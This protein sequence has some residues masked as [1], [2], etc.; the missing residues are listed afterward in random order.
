MRYALVTLLFAVVFIAG[1]ITPPSTN[2][3]TPPILPGQK[4]C[5]IVID[6]EPYTELE[7]GDVSY[8]DEVCVIRKLDYTATESP[9]VDLCISDTG[10][11]GLPLGDCQAC[12]QA[13]TRCILKIKNNEPTESGTWS[14]SAE[15]SIGDYGFI[16]DPITHTIEPGETLAFDF[17]QI[18]SPGKP[19]SSAS[20]DL[21]VESEPMFQDCH[22]ETRTR[23][24]C[25]NVTKT[26]PIEREVC[27]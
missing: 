25:A 16:K 13:M 9:K 19:I 21:N 11:N 14:V 22:Q 12:T 24:E 15:Y 17:N 20:C 26:R 27:E 7:C 5:T 8:T 23:Q 4:E 2:I 1:C 18:Y 6:Q 3:T 10:C